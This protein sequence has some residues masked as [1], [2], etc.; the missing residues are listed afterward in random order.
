VHRVQ[1]SAENAELALREVNWRRGRSARLSTSCR[2]SVELTG[3]SLVPLAHGVVAAPRLDE[4]TAIYS[5]NA[6]DHLAAAVSSLTLDVPKF[7]EQSNYADGL[8]PGSIEHLHRAVRAAWADA[9]EWVVTQARERV[10]LDRQGDGE[11]RMRVAVYFYSEPVAGAAVP[12]GTGA[13]AGHPPRVLKPREP[14][15]RRKP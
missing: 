15:S 4:M 7:L 12:T 3:D 1:P 11:Q 9:F 13:A 14:R 6:A 10:D 5:A 8:T 2:A